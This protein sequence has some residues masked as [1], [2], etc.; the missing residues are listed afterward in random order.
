MCKLVGCCVYLD[1]DI[2]LDL[3]NIP[4][5]VSVP[6]NHGHAWMNNRCLLAVAESSM[7]YECLLGSKNLA[8]VHIQLL[9]L[10]ILRACV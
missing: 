3:I 2:K 7:S 1:A 6:K 8:K 5:S 10:S 4:W 9:L